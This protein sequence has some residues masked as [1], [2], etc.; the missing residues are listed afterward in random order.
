MWFLRLELTYLKL[1]SILKRFYC[2]WSI[3][4]KQMYFNRCRNKWDLSLLLLKIFLQYFIFKLCPFQVLAENSFV[5]PLFVCTLNVL[6]DI[7]TFFFKPQFLSLTGR[8]DMIFDRFDLCLNTKTYFEENYFASY[9]V[10]YLLRTEKSSP[11]TFL[12][13]TMAVKRHNLKTCSFVLSFY[14]KHVKFFWL[15]I[16]CK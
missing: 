2:I 15:I 13:W 16:C 6:S 9:N 8:A 10:W 12:R 4:I 7:T 14:W 1:F 3:F 11:L 5:S